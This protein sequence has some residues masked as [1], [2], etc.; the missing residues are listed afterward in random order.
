MI[1]A[2]AGS[3][4]IP[5]KNIADLCGKPLLVYIARPATHLNSQ[6]FLETSPLYD[7]TSAINTADVDTLWI[8]NWRLF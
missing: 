4:G 1:P 3:K 6:H 7:V 2:H 8:W 5:N